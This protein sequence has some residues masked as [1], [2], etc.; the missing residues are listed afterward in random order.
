MCLWDGPR[1]TSFDDSDQDY[2]LKTIENWLDTV[3]QG[4]A[5]I[6]A[7]RILWDAI[8]TLLSQSVLLESSA[9]DEAGLVAPDDTKV[10]QFLEW[11]N[12]LPEHESPT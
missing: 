10:S 9:D 6:S 4:R 7:D 11:V 5:N 1:H 2:A 3:V 8:R 12:E